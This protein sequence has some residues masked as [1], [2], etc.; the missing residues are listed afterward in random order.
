MIVNK[1]SLLHSRAL[2]FSFMQLE[3]CNHWTNVFSSLLAPTT[4]HLF[5]SSIALIFVGILHQMIHE[6]LF[7][8]AKTQGICSL[9]G[10]CFCSCIFML[11]GFLAFVVFC[12][13]FW[14]GVLSSPSSTSMH[15]QKQPFL[16]FSVCWLHTRDLYQSASLDILRGSQFGG[17][18]WFLFFRVCVY[19][20]SIGEICPAPWC[21]ICAVPG[22]GILQPDAAPH[23]YSQQFPVI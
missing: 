20:L 7:L 12:F 10:M 23:P 4:H 6:Y 15:F 1:C 16:S 22:S 14:A 18:D 21:F 9:I 19:N 3:L 17:S 2:E 13:L 11:F 5:F 8:W